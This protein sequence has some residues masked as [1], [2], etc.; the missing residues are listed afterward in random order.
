MCGAGILDLLLPPKQLR[1][2][3]IARPPM[4]TNGMLHTAVSR[5]STAALATISRPRMKTESLANTVFI[6]DQ[7][8]TAPA[9]MPWMMYFWH[10]AK[11]MTIGIIASTRHAI[12]APISIL[13]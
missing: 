2:K 3:P 8:F 7:P 13:P 6:L 11:K 9:V 1:R 12:R 10:S 5:V 4:V